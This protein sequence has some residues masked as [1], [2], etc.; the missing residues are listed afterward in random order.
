MSDKCK[1]SNKQGKPCQA[2]SQRGSDWCYFHDP[3]KEADR[4][5]ARIKGGR[6]RRYEDVSKYKVEHLDNPEA[7][8]KV[9]EDTLKATLLQ[10]NSTSRS[11]AINALAQ[12]A[13]KL[14]ETV[15]LHDRI[16]K[17]EQILQRRRMS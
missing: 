5:V 15:D 3:E 14:Y 4:A 12:T 2:T 16:T 10:D 9:L 6:K 13:L 1:G 11:R 7:I 17:L 8:L